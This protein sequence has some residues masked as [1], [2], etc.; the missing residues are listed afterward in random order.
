MAKHF[1]RSTHKKWNAQ[2]THPIIHEFF[3][4]YCWTLCRGRR[5]T[6]HHFVR[7]FR[8]L[9]TI[10]VPSPFVQFSFFN[11]FAVSFF[12]PSILCLSVRAHRLWHIPLCCTWFRLKL[13]ELTVTIQSCSEIG[14][15]RKTKGREKWVISVSTFDLLRLCIVT[16]VSRVQVFGHLREVEAM[17][18]GWL[19]LMMIIIKSST[20]F[21]PFSHLLNGKITFSLSLYHHSLCLTYTQLWYE[22]STKSRRTWSPPAYVSTTERKRD[23]TI[24]W[25]MTSQWQHTLH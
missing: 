2:R 25:L 19:K 8:W 17:W 24:R 16:S 15:K 6:I 9:L 20:F 23:K 14:R 12:L 7:T 5:F 1:A 10:A 4:F 21:L 18:N 13:R 3:R 11:A 22:E